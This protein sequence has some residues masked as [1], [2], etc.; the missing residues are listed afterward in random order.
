MWHRFNSNIGW[1][2]LLK[3]RL[4]D[5]GWTLYKLANKYALNAVEENSPARRYHSAIGKFFEEPE[6]SKSK[7]VEN[8]IKAQSLPDRDFC[9]ASFALGGEII[10]IW[11]NTDT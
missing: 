11:D 10:I 9:P 8:V 5:L 1:K 6:R 4:E 7:T 3:R 2:E